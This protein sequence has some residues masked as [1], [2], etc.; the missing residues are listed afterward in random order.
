MAPKAV[1][2]YPSASCISNPSAALGLQHDVEAAPKGSAILNA[3]VL[4]ADRRDTQL[5]IDATDAAGRCHDQGVFGLA[6][7]PRGGL[8]LVDVTTVSA[9]N[10]IGLT[11]HI[12]ESHTVNVDPRRPHIAY[13]VTSDS[14]TVNAEGRRTNEI[15]DGSLALDG[16]E[17]VDMSSCMN[18]PGGTTIE[19]KRAACRPQVYRYR[20]PSTEMALGHTNKGNVSGCHELEVYPDDRLTCAGGGAMIALD[21]KG[22]FDDRGTPNNSSDD[23]PRGTPRPALAPGCAL[24]RQRV[25]RGP[26]ELHRRRGSAVRLHRGHRLR[27]R[28]R[29]HQLGQVRDRDRRARRRSGAAGRLL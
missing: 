27:S 5:L 7:A 25:P 24:D 26:R 17:V 13:S 16:F 14:V 20:Y 19:Q 6:Q 4:A 23:K 28:G 18:F 9:P 15:N 22:A 29:A 3:D 2:T 12:G 10:A 8:E 11:S 1:K 21:M